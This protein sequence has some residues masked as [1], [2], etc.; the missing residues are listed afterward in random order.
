MSIY[1]VGTNSN[2]NLCFGTVQKK[3][4]T[5]ET[6]A[7]H[8]VSGDNEKS[9]QTDVIPK[10]YIGASFA[11]LI[12]SGQYARNRI[13]VVNKIVS[14]RSAD[15]GEIYVSFFTDEKI[16]CNDES[17]KKVWEINIEN[18]RQADK[19]KEYFANYK[20]DRDYV[21]EFY[22][23]DNVKMALSK[24]FWIDLFKGIDGE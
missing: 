10:Q 16:T 19:V 6:F 11:D 8:E 17:G 21:Q 22:S 24:D 23:G 5:N 9:I 13:S 7:M 15:N 18:E 2:T 20:P 14:S 3:E 1:T 12:N 4:E